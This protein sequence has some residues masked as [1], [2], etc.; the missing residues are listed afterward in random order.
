MIKQRPSASLSGHFPKKRLGQH[1]LKNQDVIRKIIQSAR[2]DQ[3]DTVVEIG[4]GLGALTIPLAGVVGRIIAI[5]KDPELVEALKQRLDRENIRN[6]EPVEADILRFDPWQP[7]G[8]SPEGGKVIGNLPYNISSPLL[9]K[10]IERRERIDR[11]VLMF[12]Y[13]F[14]QRLTA[15]PGSRAYGS[16][17][18][19]TQYYARV[20]P[21]LRVGSDNFYPKPKVGSMVIEIDFSKPFPRRAEDDVIFKRTVRR[22]FQHKRK[23]LL[24][25]LWGSGL[26][27]TKEE[28]KSILLKAGLDPERRAETLTID[29]FLYLAS[30]LATI[31]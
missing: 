21:L 29:E 20:S 13:E 26:L 1:F 9:E 15:S 22:S 5:E 3:S 12:Q 28:L 4:P 30:V 25:S 24:N 11:A 18:V 2:F 23:T 10:L 14:A 31:A 8:L 7:A 6:V 27:L 17:S 16:L 19:L